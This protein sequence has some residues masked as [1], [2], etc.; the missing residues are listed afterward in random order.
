MAEGLQNHFCGN[1]PFIN[2]TEILIVASVFPSALAVH[3]ISCRSFVSS[4]GA[5]TS[6]LPVV[7]ILRF[8]GKIARPTLCRPA[9]RHLHCNANVLGRV[10]VVVQLQR[11]RHVAP[12]WI[13]IS[14]SFTFGSFVIP[15]ACSHGPPMTDTLA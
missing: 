1:A 11:H 3:S 2:W 12:R 8:K 10:G 6:N 15:C 7:V 14:G 5:S 4:L 13:A 9:I